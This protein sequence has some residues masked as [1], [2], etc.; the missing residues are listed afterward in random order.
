VPA[1]RGGWTDF[2]A[3]WNSNEAALSLLARSG[4]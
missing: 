4:K 2:G 1:D 3:M